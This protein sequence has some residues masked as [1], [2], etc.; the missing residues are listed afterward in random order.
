MGAVTIYEIRYTEDEIFIYDDH[1]DVVDVFDP[2]YDDEHTR[3]EVYADVSA[4]EA[5]SILERH[6]LSFAATGGSWAADPDGSY[7]SNYATAEHVETTGHLHG[8]HPRVEEAIMAHV[9]GPG[10]VLEMAEAEATAR[11]LGIEATKVEIRRAEEIAPAFEML[12]GA[13][14]RC[15]CAPIHS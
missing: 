1:G 11:K 15:M 12:R 8:F 7:I 6:G 14:K 9:G 5:A 2:P 10:A 4:S 3:S 13:L